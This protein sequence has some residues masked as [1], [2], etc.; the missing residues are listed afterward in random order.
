M[1]LWCGFRPA[2]LI[3]GTVLL[4]STRSASRLVRIG[5]A[6]AALAGLYGLFFGVDPA[7]I[8]AIAATAFAW[9]CTIASTRSADNGRLAV[10][11]TP[12]DQ[13]G[14]VRE[15]PRPMVM[16]LGV[17]PLV[18]CSLAV[19]SLRSPSS[20]AVAAAGILG[21]VALWM[22]MRASDASG[23]PRDDV[24]L[25]AVVLAVSALPLTIWSVT[26]IAASG[27]DPITPYV[28]CVW[29]LANVPI[30]LQGILFIGPARDAFDRERRDRKLR[31]DVESP[32]KSQSSI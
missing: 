5:A 20:L 31:R 6:T 1:G 18:V 2:S 26:A 27:A 11:G 8:S 3:S 23:T 4:S 14:A 17:A 15:A 29:V 30:L 24:S 25:A 21:T 7:I 28:A 13:R 10:S 16:L 32:A 9:S 12:A 19:A 22:S